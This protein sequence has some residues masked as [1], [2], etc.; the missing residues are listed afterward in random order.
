MRLRGLAVYAISQSIPR[1]IRIRNLFVVY[2][3]WSIHSLFAV[4]F[5][6]LVITQSRSNILVRLVKGASDCQD[7]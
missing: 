5:T 2:S 6:V 4:Y 1:S 7:V 3:S